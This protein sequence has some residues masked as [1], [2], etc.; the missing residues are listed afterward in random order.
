M[1][2][3]RNRSGSG[4]QAP[5]SETET[6]AGPPANA[7]R[8][9][10]RSS[11]EAVSSSAI[12]H[13]RGLPVPPAPGTEVHAALLRGPEDP[14]PL[15]LREIHGQGV[16]DG[17]GAGPEPEPLEIP[18]E[19]QGEAADP[20]GDPDEAFRAVP[21]RVACGD[22]CREHLRGADVAGRPVAADMLLAGLERQAE[23][24]P[25]MRVAGGPHHPTGRTAG[26]AQPGGE[27]RRVGTAAGHRHPETLTRSD[28]DIGAEFAGRFEQGQRQEIRGG[29]HQRARLP[30]LLHQRPP[31]A[32]P[33]AGV[34]VLHRH[35]TD[36]RAEVVV[37]GEIADLEVDAHRPRP[38]L[39]HRQGLRMEV[40]VGDEGLPAPYRA[41]AH[42][43]GLGGGRRLVEEGSAGD[44]QAGQVGNHGLEVQKDLQ[45]P[46]GDLR[47]VRGVLRVPARVLEDVPQQDRRRHG[48]VVALPDEAAEHLV[49]AGDGSQLGQRVRFG[50]RRRQP[51]FPLQ[52]DV[53]RDRLVCQHIQG[54]DAQSV[55]HVSLLGGAGADVATHERRRSRARVGHG[56]TGWR[57]CANPRKDGGRSQ[58]KS[59]PA[60]D[61]ER[62]RWR[63]RR[64]PRNRVE[65][66]R[67][68]H[69]RPERRAILAV[70]NA[71]AGSAATGVREGGG[72][73]IGQ[74]ANKPRLHPDPPA[75]HAGAGRGAAPQPPVSGAPS[76]ARCGRPPRRVPR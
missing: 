40:P 70:R 23:R 56:G 66:C 50:K 30:G 51:Q 45:T 6:G 38:R 26:E 53:R 27:K 8:I 25:A 31:V 61:G 65:A 62:S 37:L 42:G 20:A 11:G 13:S 2:R 58:E 60:N 28:R 72:G 1:L 39:H 12:P 76:S 67:T 16:E 21:G 43:H 69:P 41:A 71:G 32:N 64:R 15:D 14:V 29:H 33:A 10:S 5:G 44:R 34:G 48:A 9:A 52:P 49:A 54:A 17:V 63:C 36:I 59:C 57:R 74:Q 46:L 47:L 18:P 4:S 24:G 19:C 35:P 3:R 7:T 22:Q 68:A 73:A 75:G 55:E